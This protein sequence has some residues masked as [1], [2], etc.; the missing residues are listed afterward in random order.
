MFRR[1]RKPLYYKPRGRYLAW[2]GAAMTIIAG[3]AIVA[4]M[5]GFALPTAL[6]RGTAAPPVVET[7]TGAGRVRH[8]AAIEIGDRLVEFFGVEL[9]PAG[10]VCDDGNG[11]RLDCAAVARGVLAGL[12]G[13]GGVHCV[14]RGAVEA[15]FL[16]TCYT[17]NGEDL[18]AGLVAGGW[19]MSASADGRGP[20]GI[21]EDDARAANRGI[22][23][24][25]DA[26]PRP[27][28]AQEPV[29]DSAAVTPPAIPNAAELPAR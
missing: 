4:H 24:A 25:A 18:A 9:P 6:T 19:A 3:G 26:P 16:A 11:N 15:R 14:R 1:R 2:A 13:V 10:L 22:W 17:A 20:Y 23:S 27:A 8:A 28:A 5:G 7:I 21:A 29:G 12:I